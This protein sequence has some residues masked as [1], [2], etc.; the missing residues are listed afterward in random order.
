MRNPH[1]RQS[2]GKQAASRKTEESTTEWG[3]TM[4][5]D[6]LLG[7]EIEEKSKAAHGR[8]EILRKTLQYTS[9]NSGNARR[10]WSLHWR[11]P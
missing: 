7:A 1:L 10:V 4:E 9:L 3:K 5:R 2:A 6:P 8:E 11:W